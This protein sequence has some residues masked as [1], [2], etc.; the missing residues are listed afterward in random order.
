MSAINSIVNVQISRQTT[1][2]TQVGFG[3]G[4]FLSNQAVFS[5]RIKSYSSAT[6]VTQDTL[7][8]AD[9]QLFASK[10]FGQEIRPTILYV[11]KKGRDLPSIKVLTLDADLIASNTYNT[12]VDGGTPIATV[13]ASDHATTLAAHATAIQGEGTVVTAVSDPI[14]RTITITH[15]TP[16]GTNVFTAVSV[17]GGASQANVAET[18]TQFADTVLTDVASIQAAQLINDDWY[19]LAVYTRVKAD[20]E[21]LA[22]FIQPLLKIYIA[23]TADSDVITSAGTDVATALK[24]AAF[25]RTAI[26][27]SNDEANFPEAAWMGGR[28]PL[29]PG[30]TTWKF[31]TLSGITRD[32]LNTTE[33][34]NALGK[35][36]NIYTTVG[37]VNMTC[38]GKMASGEFIDVIRGVD[39]IQARMTENIFSALVNSEKIPFTDDGVSIIVNQMQQILDQAVA[40]TILTND[41]APSITA[42]LVA[43]VS[44]N[45][46]ANRTLPNV[47][48]QG[49]LAGAIHLVTVLGVVTV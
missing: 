40:N 41:P 29:L 48:F 45:D 2:V 46:K 42:P 3:A 18:Q 6:E 32:L 33:R 35:N 21:L 13:F 12:T 30:S 8:G 47:T 49:T 38:D 27:F 37:G 16:G 26:M 36:S 1:A 34:N 31:K 19:A 17:T 7:S 5:E 25:D 14:A 28:L 15:T 23:I 24:A 10:Y 44:A 22:A 43:N 9:S 20:I 4:N 39:W 11:T